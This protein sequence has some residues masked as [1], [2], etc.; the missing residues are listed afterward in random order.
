MHIWKYRHEPETNLTL[1][2]FT[3]FVGTKDLGRRT[4][5]KFGTFSSDNLYVKKA[6]GRHDAAAAE[7]GADP[8]TTSETSERMWQSSCPSARAAASMSIL[9]KHKL[10]VHG[11]A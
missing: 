8:P 10:R 1:S 7:G 6:H 2:P 3:F 4:C 11:K 9:S 5:A